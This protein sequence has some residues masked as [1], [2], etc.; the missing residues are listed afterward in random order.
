[1][2][3][4][5]PLHELPSKDP[6]QFVTL[7]DVEVT[8]IEWLWKPYIP[9][10]ALTLLIGDG[11]YGKSWLTC[12]L[13]AD[14][15]R[16]V[17]LPGQDA[18]RPQKVLMISAED[19]IS[20]VIKPKMILLGADMA[21]IHAS[22]R[23]FEL[24][25]DSMTHLVRNIK[26]YDVAVV[27]LDP[28]V[29]YLGGKVDMFRSNEVRPWLTQLGD[30]AKN[31]NTAI[32]AVHHVRKAGE[33]NTQHRAMGS[34]DFVNGVRSTLL[35]DVSKG[36]QRFMAHVKSNWAANGPTLAYTFGAE[37]FSWQ[38]E[39]D[40]SAADSHKVST[41]RRG[42]IEDWMKDQLKDG[43]VL[44]ARMLDAA[45]EYGYSDRTLARAKNG[46]VNS[47]NSRGLWYWKL[48]D[49]VM[50]E[51]QKANGVEEVDP[52]EII[53]QIARQTSEA[54]PLAAKEDNLAYAMRVMAEK[55]GP[56]A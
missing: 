53:A 43:P 15:T 26:E 34:A 4:V 32:V 52:G 55:R 11:G 42:A 10:G 44:A 21:H 50:E 23:G 18:V 6:F 7:S 19:G 1:M 38:G 47:Y 28:L 48:E 25:A 30:V 8:P 13:A 45:M 35:V 24:D 41:T 5:K 22:D 49:A 37:G 31:T 14:L 9:K 46:L 39:F 33:G 51:M 54:S 2:I 20:Q 27:F 17:A 3:S 16:G 29:V 40:G 56:R 36:G 12:A